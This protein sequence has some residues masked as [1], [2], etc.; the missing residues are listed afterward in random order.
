MIFESDEDLEGIGGRKGR[1]RNRRLRAEEPGRN[2][3]NKNGKEED[4]TKPWIGCSCGAWV[5]GHK[6]SLGPQKK[7]ARQK[8]VS[9]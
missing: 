7:F 4:G 9:E 3:K 2:G 8:K 1:G 6:R 5:Q